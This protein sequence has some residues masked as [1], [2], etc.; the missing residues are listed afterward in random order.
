MSDNQNPDSKMETLEMDLSEVDVSKDGVLDITT[1]AQI[2]ILEG[3][4]AISN[5]LSKKK[6]MFLVF[7]SLVGIGILTM[8]HQINE[9]GVFGAMLLFP[10]IAAFVLYALDLMVKTANDL[11]YYEQ[12]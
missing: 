1:E 8:P 12:R 3:I 7:R 10:T 4:G 9:I 11:G 5:G 2:T 6:A